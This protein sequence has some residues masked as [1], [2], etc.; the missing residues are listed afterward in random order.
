MQNELGSSD[1]EKLVILTSLISQED[2]GKYDQMVSTGEP[3]D[4][5]ESTDS[6]SIYST[7]F[8]CFQLNLNTKITFENLRFR[9]L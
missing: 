1:F 4:L 9:C 6:C 7:L 8:S 3:D 5:M 2:S